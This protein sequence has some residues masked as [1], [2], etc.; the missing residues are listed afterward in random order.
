M[1]FID[2]VILMLIFVPAMLLADILKSVL[3]AAGRAT[4]KWIVRKFK[5]ISD[6]I[7]MGI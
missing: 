2:V 5:C 1:E 7:D 6:D 3:K 4:V